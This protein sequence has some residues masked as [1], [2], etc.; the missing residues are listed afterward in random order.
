[1]KP[2]TSDWYAANRDRIFRIAAQ[3]RAAQNLAAQPP[4]L[5]R[6]RQRRKVQPTIKV[7]GICGSDFLAATLRATVC[8]VACKERLRKMSISQWREIN[9][10][11]VNEVRRKR[12]NRLKGDR[13]YRKNNRIRIKEQ[14]REYREVNGDRI[15]AADRERYETDYKR[16]R[17]RIVNRERIKEQQREYSYQRRLAYV[18]FQLLE[19]IPEH[20]P[21]ETKR[22]IAYQ[23]MKKHH[24]EFFFRREHDQ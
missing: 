22:T 24:P 9:R 5:A 11:H 10:D 23:T 7:C 17:L 12:A 21:L 19:L 6:R 15:R 1:M 13:E 2:P 20:L 18:A 14:K 3:N 4:K 8:S 16:R